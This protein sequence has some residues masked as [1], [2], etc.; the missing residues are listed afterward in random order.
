MIRPLP[1]NECIHV[2][3]PKG[4]DVSPF[5]AS[6]LHPLSSSL[7]AGVVPL[8]WGL[9]LAESHQDA[10]RSLPQHQLRQHRVDTNAP[11]HLHV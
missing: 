6:T 9:L 1:L 8:C 2:L 3:P 5:S 4:G 10:F 11:R 7:H